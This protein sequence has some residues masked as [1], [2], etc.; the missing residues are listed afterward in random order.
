MDDPSFEIVTFG[1]NKHKEMALKVY[2]LCTLVFVS[3]HNIHMYVCNHHQRL[4]T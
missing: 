3:L 2:Q 1:I 4:P